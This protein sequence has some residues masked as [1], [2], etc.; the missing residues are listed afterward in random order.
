M[1]L[2]RDAAD[3][4]AVLA[5]CRKFDAPLLPR[6]GGTSLAGQCC[7]VAVVMDCSKYM[8]QIL[9]VDPDRK[10]ARVEP[11][12]VC[13]QLLHATEPHHL[14]LPPDPATHLWCTLGGMIG[15]DSCGPHSV[16]SERTGRTVDHVE[17]LE[18]LTYD[19]LRLRVGKTSDDELARIIAEG[20]RRGSLYAKLKRLRDEY[21][22]LIRER[23]PRI[24]RRVS[25]YNLDALLPENGFDVAKALVGSEGTC[26]TVLEATLRLV[27]Y[28]PQRALAVLAYPEIFT[29][30]D[31]VP[32]IL[33]AKPMALEAID[34]RFVTNLLKKH[35]LKEQIALLPRP[36][37]TEGHESAGGWLMVEFGGETAEE[38]RDKAQRLVDSI[39]S[40][41]GGPAAKV[42]A[43]AEEQA[44]IWKVRDSGLG[45]D[46][47]V[48]G[49]PENWEGWED[50]AVHPD[51]LGKYLRDLKQLME[52][53]GYLGTLYGHFGQGCVHTRLTFD[54]R[55]AA[56][57]ATY[58]RFISDAADL[59]V[60]HGGSLSG[61]HGDGQSRAEML[62][63]M[64]GPELVQA[65]GEFKGI[66]DPADKMNPGKVVHPYR[67]DQNLRLGTD[68]KP[69]AAKTHFK[70]TADH[71]S[72]AQATLRCV[73]V[74][75]CRNVQTTDQT[76]CPSYQ[77][78]LEE[79]HS[80]RGRAR[81]LFEMMQ[82]EELPDRWRDQHVKDAL[83]LCLAC[84]GCKTDCPVH[85][86][87][88]TY[89]A[90]F[91]SHY[92]AGRVRPV[93]AYSIGLIHLWA[94]LAAKA[95][96]VANFL[97]QTPVLR[98]AFKAAGGLAPRRKVPAFAAEPFTDWYRRRG[99]RGHA[100]QPRVL[101][102]A[103]T[104]NTY[105]HVEV[106][107][108]AVE[109]LE[110]AGFRVD[111]PQVSHAGLCC[112][113]PLYDYGFLGQAEGLLRRTL[114]AL[115]EDISA[116]VPLVG[117]EPSCVTVFR[118]ELTNLFPNDEQA[119]RLSQ[120][121]FL[122]DEFIADH[123]PDFRP[124]PLRA[125]ALVHGHCHQ[126]ALLNPEATACVL[127]RLGVDYQVLDSGC[128]GLAGSFGFER[129]HYDISMQIGERVL[130]PAARKADQTTLLI[131]DGFSCREQVEHG[132]QRR[133][134]H[135]AQVLR[136][137]LHSA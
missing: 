104:F 119:K 127:D 43:S 77:V 74:G 18:V 11:G 71:N 41:R 66:W 124:P 33:R 52:R 96:A 133:T 99:P 120:Q 87:V 116:G 97:T 70:F 44:A 21:A 6:G 4:E 28:P 58:H 114:A 89:K 29:A 32:E 122:F 36:H 25:G 98:S 103:D 137:A 108:A 107:K 27:Y 13:D 8:R 76:M 84:K 46:A 34:H 57:I 93:A 75:K 56:G 110:A 102:W 10:L 68:F 62:P 9:D 67:I 35:L 51:N 86:D 47:Y 126:K 131:T 12:V 16:M 117:L 5:A 123:A 92:Y 83:D 14:R 95:P 125:K 128:C 39:K 113:R 136:L 59:V 48:P 7:N 73:G 80:T 72:F 105:F 69:P 82:G 45:A 121:T 26:V 60:R 101:L 42:F 115:D 130:L 54:L 106:A 30:G 17:A 129:D 112:G 1:V 100:G 64:F 40:Q 132:A 135:L 23:F 24:P 49:E 3:V 65:F 63:K 50:S 81:L 55:T 19:G 94:R 15:N 109:V 22:P 85:V 20:G 61:E 78:T 91:L 2:P 79:M 118:D 88:A 38:A 31:H 37:D 134:L 53:Y 111:V 90:E